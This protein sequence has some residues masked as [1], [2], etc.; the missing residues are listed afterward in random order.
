MASRWRH[1]ADLTD[2]VFEPQIYRT[3]SVCAKPEVRDPLLGRENAQ[4]KWRRTARVNM[5]PYSHSKY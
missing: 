1:C 5:Q 3:D 4:S 2:P